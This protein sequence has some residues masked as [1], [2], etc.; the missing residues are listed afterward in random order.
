MWAV[1][2]RILGPIANW[3]G[4]IILLPLI[5]DFI[6]QLQQRAEDKRKREE[7]HKEIEDGVK[8]IEEAVTPEDQEAALEE[9]AR[10]AR[11]RRN[12]S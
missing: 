2:I 10:K 1:V 4:K 11:A 12:N 6:K 9:L 3:V 5:I 8:K 7:A